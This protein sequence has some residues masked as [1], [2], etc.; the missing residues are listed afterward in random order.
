C[1]EL[2]KARGR[3]LDVARLHRRAARAVV[4]PGPEQ[5]EGIGADALD[6]LRA[7]GIHAPAAERVRHA[8]VVELAVRERG[9]DET[10]AAATRADEDL[11]ASTRRRRIAGRR[12]DVAAREGI[13]KV[14]ERR[15][16]RADRFEKRC[17][18][19]A[20]MHERA[21]RLERGRRAERLHVQA[22]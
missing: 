12:A 22:R 13:A 15:P 10:D 19:L 18:R 17:E 14:V 21:L 4:A 20:R 7:A 16:P 9:T 8:D 3:A 2:S 11:R 6:P 1:L 5:V